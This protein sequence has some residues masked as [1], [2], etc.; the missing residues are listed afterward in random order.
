LTIITL[1]G[2]SVAF[3]VQ[4]LSARKKAAWLEYELE[5]ERSQTQ[6]A[7]PAPPNPERGEGQPDE[8]RPR[9]QPP[10]G[11][12]VPWPLLL[13]LFPCVIAAVVAAGVFYA[14][15]D[16]TWR[17]LADAEDELKR[18]RKEEKR[19]RAREKRL[20]EEQ[21][22]LEARLQ[23]PP[24]PGQPAAATAKRAEE[25]ELE[26]RGRDLQRQ[27]DE[28][29]RRL[30]TEDPARSTPSAS[31][32]QHD[33]L[34]RAFRRLR[35]QGFRSLSEALFRFGKARLQAEPPTAAHFL[36]FLADRIL[37][38]GG[39]LV[40]GQ[41]MAE[42]AGDVAPISPREA[43]RDTIRQALEHKLGAPLSDELARQLDLLVDESLTLLGGV[44]GGS[45]PGKLLVPA[46]GT[47][48]DPAYH[49]TWDGTSPA[50]GARIYA[51]L[52]PGYLVVG[53]GEVRVAEKAQVA[54]KKP[55]RGGR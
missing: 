41:Q 17:D 14:W 28:A 23:A 45:P 9:P 4:W 40:L 48:F 1:L 24:T 55:D 44:F 7:Q 31:G 34:Q 21:Q 53:P 30:A 3:C 29:L 47:T 8:T 15:Y 49:E 32:T 2:G 46:E 35:S 20:T 19:L 11:G 52:F 36:A 43:V 10:R 12:A 26:K 16:R 39:Q 6:S 33:A 22:A 25:W 54:A 42:A 50:S 37:V 5:M 18:V 27:L 13:I 38:W 51:T